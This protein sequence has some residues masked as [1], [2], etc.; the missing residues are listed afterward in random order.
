[1]AAGRLAPHTGWQLILLAALSNLAFKAG[2]V[3]FLGD[4][5]LLRRIAVLFGLTIAGGLL[6]F[7]LWPAG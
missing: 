7:W 3:A 5:R 1:V 4:R 2:L 6:V